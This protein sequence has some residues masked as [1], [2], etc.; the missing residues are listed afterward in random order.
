VINFLNTSAGV[1]Y[2]GY[3]RSSPCAVKQMKLS[4][5]AVDSQKQLEEFKKEAAIMK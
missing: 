4:G 1:V 5:A 3:W 2:K